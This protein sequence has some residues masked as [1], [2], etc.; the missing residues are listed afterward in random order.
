MMFSI[1]I[2]QQLKLLLW[3]TSEHGDIRIYMNVYILYTSKNI[4]ILKLLFFRY[5]ASSELLGCCGLKG[6]PVWHFSSS[7]RS[8]KTKLLINQRNKPSKMKLL[9][10]K[11]SEHG[12]I[13]IYMNVYILYTS[14]NIGILKLLFFRYFASSELLGCCGLKGSPVWH[15]SSSRR[16]IKTKL[17]INQRNKPSKIQ[18]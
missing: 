18:I 3:K 16:S 13:R 15:F 6:S 9:L 10:W 17:L 5:F 11:T 7:R 14:K 12:D 4:G 1:W 8:I 2:V